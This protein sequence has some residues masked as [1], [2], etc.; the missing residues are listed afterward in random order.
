[1]ML[2]RERQRNPGFEKLELQRQA[3]SKTR[4]EHI[5][6]WQDLRESRNYAVEHENMQARRRREEMRKR[7]TTR[8][9]TTKELVA[10]WERRYSMAERGWARE[11]RML[12]TKYGD[13]YRDNLG[14]NS[15]TDSEKPVMFVHISNSGGY[16]GV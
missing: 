2:R 8:K 9:K 12:H 3:R 6:R 14:V 13:M 7:K 5:K 10:E 1:M 4:L 16:G 15:N 11:S